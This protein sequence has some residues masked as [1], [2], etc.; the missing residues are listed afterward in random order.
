MKICRLQVHHY[1]LS[2]IIYLTLLMLIS[3][4]GY[5]EPQNSKWLLAF[6]SFRVCVCV[7]VCVCVKLHPLAIRLTVPYLLE[8]IKS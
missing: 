1:V 3:L 4:L 5:K 7:C 6:I 8:G 2:Y